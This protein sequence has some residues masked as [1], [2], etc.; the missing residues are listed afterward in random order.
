MPDYKTLKHNSD[1]YYA[2]CVNDLMFKDDIEIVS[3]PLYYAPLLVRIIFAIHHSERINKF[4]KLPFKSIWFPRY[5]KNKFKEKRPLC[6][7][8]LNYHLSND[9]LNYLKTTF[10]GCKIVCL[11]RDL[12]KIYEKK[13]PGFPLNKL[14]DLEFSFDKNECLKYGFIHF[15]E[16]ESKI[17]VPRASNYPLSD[18]FFAGKAKDRLNVLLSIYDLMTKNGINCDFV[19]TGVAKR[20]QVV[21]KGI[22]YL[23]RGISYKEFLYR[24]VNSNCLLEINQ[25]GAV[26]FTSR[27]LEAVMYNKKLITNNLNI[28]NSEFYNTKYIQC[29]KDVSSI[30]CSFVKKDIGIINYN[31]S[32]EFSP[33]VLINRIDDMLAK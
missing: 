22:H 27:F 18:L 12:I 33:L 25:K 4:I 16:F 31:Y 2:I 7:I 6:F 20:N 30:D 14:F 28:K 21:R 32:N 17:C 24:S 9:Y 10:V 13:Y 3:S 23:K 26:G 1:G 5:F 8:V 19:L 29:F 15:D 11:H